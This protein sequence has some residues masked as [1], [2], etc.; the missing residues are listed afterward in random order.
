MQMRR[1]KGRKKSEKKTHTSTPREVK[2]T[3]SKKVDLCLEVNTA[4]L[5]AFKNGVRICLHLFYSRT[6]KEFL[7]CSLAAV[8]TYAVVD[9]S[10]KK[11]SKKDKKVE[12]EKPQ[13]APPEYAAVDKSKKKKKKE[14]PEATYAEVD[15]S[16]KSK[17][18]C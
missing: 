4:I 5:K 15:K 9:K 11:A 1:S 3:F 14:E 17:K 13:A 6:N 16:K 8:P 2:H 18:V 12:E 10:A 7:V